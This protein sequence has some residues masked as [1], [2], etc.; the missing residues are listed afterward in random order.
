MLRSSSRSRGQ[1][2]PLAALVAIAL[3]CTGVVLYAGT[4]SELYPGVTDR[5]PADATL[6]GI[7]NSVGSDGVYHETRDRSELHQDDAVPAGYTVYVEVTTAVDG[8]P[9]LVDSILVDSD[10]DVQYNAGGID[11]PTD[12]A[13]ASRSITVQ[14]HRDPAGD[15]RGGT[16]RVEA[17]QE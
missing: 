4:V 8:E 7:W 5:D 17:W 15:T 16:L 3:V 11:R 14:L 10:G 6:D 13:M 1:T 12:P 2:E 9:E